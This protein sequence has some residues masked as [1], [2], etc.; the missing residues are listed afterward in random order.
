LGCTTIKNAPKFGAFFI[1]KTKEFYFA[2]ATGFAAGV[3]GLTAVETGF[4]AVFVDF[5]VLAGF[6]AGV[7]VF[8]GSF[9]V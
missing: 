2:G 5:A 9:L 7:S 4:F 6:A 3:A 8:A 1:K